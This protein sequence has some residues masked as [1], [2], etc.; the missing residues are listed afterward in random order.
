MSF[1]RASSE[2]GKA[3]TCSASSFGARLSSVT[4]RSIT[5]RPYRAS[6]K[7]NAGLSASR[8][9]K[10]VEVEILA[11]ARD[12]DAEVAEEAERLRA[13]LRVL[14]VHGAAPGEAHRSALVK[15]VALGVAAEVVVIVED[16]YPRLRAVALAVKVRGREP[17][18]TAAN[19][20]EVVSL[21]EQLGLSKCR[22]S[23]A[24]ACAT[25]KDPGAHRVDR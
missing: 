24:S 18:D 13:V 8:E 1:A 3:S 14:D 19:H 22:P 12:V 9:P 7:S 21:V 15:F 2:S 6:L 10:P 5:S 25:S 17:A 4:P 23:R 11:Q 16:Q 20:D